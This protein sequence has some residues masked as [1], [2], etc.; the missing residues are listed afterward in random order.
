ML[1]FVVNPVAGKG[2]TI[3]VFKR[4]RELLDEQHIEYEYVFTEYVGHAEELARAACAAGKKQIVA[5]GGDG[6]IREVGCGMYGSDA[7]LGIIPAGSGN[8]LARSLQISFKT[9]ESLGAI[10]GG[11]TRRIDVG[12]ASD[13]VFFNAAGL[14]FDVDVLL[15]MD[16]VKRFLAGSFA[17][18]ASVIMAIFGASFITVELEL[19][20]TR[21]KRDLLLIAITNGVYY[22]GGMKVSPGAEV[23]DGIFEVSL[24]NKLPKWR[25]PLLLPKFLNGSYRALSVVE[26]YR[27]RHIKVHASPVSK[28]Q[29]DGAI[30]GQT[31]IEFSILPAALSVF[32][33]V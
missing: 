15:A 14:G 12:M 28:L 9:Q 4:V 30:M 24:I 11:A 17:Y 31:P 6:T 16:K 8:D 3:K 18:A 13:M 10:L 23:D 33:P 32:V 19:D 5:V 2:R 27:A 21:I 25:I 29:L 26:H 20:G 7:V 22:G 1:Y